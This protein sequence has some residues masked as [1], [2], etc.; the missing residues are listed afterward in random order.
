MNRLPEKRSCFININRG[1]EGAKACVTINVGS[2]TGAEYEPDDIVD[3][4]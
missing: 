4:Q 3:F 2:E 1:A